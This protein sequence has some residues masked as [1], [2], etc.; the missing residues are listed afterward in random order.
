MSEI[1]DQVA[2]TQH[3]ETRNVLVC[4]RRTTIRME[5]VFWDLLEAIARKEG[6]KVEH[7]LSEIDARRGSLNRTAAV[8]VFA[9]TYFHDDPEPR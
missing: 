6:V 4:G 5:S 3:R 2:D 8:R 1:N 7:L 9:V